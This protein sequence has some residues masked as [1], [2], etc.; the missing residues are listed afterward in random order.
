VTVYFY[1]NPQL[2]KVYNVENNIDISYL[3]WTVDEDRDLL[4]V[5]EIYKRLYS[6]KDI[7][8]M[9]DILNILKK[10]PYLIEINKDVKQKSIR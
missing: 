3:R 10:E 1:E 8:L 5:R 2:F 4:F 7:F 9:M 6:E